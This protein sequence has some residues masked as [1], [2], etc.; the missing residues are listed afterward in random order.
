MKKDYRKQKFF[1]LVSLADFIAECNEDGEYDRTAWE[2]H[3]WLDEKCKNKTA[4]LKVIL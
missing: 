3:K 2:F 1:S 4:E